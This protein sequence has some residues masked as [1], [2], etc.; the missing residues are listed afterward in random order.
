MLIVQT[1]AELFAVLQLIWI[2]QLQPCLA[3]SGP[4]EMT[5]QAVLFD[6]GDTLIRLRGQ[7]GALVRMAAEGLGVSA[8]AEAA[9]RLWDEV[10]AAAGTPA[11][12]A[13]GRDLAGA[14]HR[15][16]WT[17]LYAAAGAER[18]AEGLSEALYDLT[19]DPTS[20]EPCPGA[21]DVLRAL[22]LADVP[23]A[24]VSDT[25]FDLR[26]VFEGLGLS[27]WVDAW[28]LSYEFGVCKP[29]PAVFRTACSL[30]GA[31][32]ADTLM[33][34]DNPMTD[35]GAVAAGCRVLLVPPAD[36]QVSHLRDVLSLVATPTHAP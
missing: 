9:G 32:P 16:V 8:E 22:R 17:S 15:Q 5:I 31:A 12:L 36:K 34:G 26:P 21:E 33:V 10:L 1:A 25:G 13:K 11:E 27:L 23:V 3:T 19:I 30:L 4:A 29:D 18:L 28:V 2:P 7:D 14:R 20:W 35:G 6:A 24:V